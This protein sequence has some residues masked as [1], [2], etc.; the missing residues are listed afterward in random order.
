ML[1]NWFPTS[2]QHTRRNLVHSQDST[3]FLVV[4]LVSHFSL[5]HTFYD[6]Y[7]S[8]P[9]QSLIT[10]RS[11]LHPPLPIPWSLPSPFPAGPLP[12]PLTKAS[13]T[14]QP[15]P[16][17]PRPFPASTGIAPLARSTPWPSR[18]F[19]CTPRSP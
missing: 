11:S 13:P 16:P 4:F 2:T 19:P 9:L 8:F 18:T 5:V 17:P 7:K 12:A 15:V 6:F 1:P 3:D 14:S 10:A